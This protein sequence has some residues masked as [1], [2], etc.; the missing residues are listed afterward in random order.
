VPSGS[1]DAVASKVTVWPVTGVAGVK[2]KLAVGF[3]SVTVTVTVAVLLLAAW[4][5]SGT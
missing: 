1:T 3:S 2:V 5:P 4:V